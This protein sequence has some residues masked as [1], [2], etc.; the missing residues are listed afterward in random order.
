[1]TRDCLMDDVHSLYF[2][3]FVLGSLRAEAAGNQEKLKDI[4]QLEMCPVIF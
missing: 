2:I 4:K 3:S 1:M